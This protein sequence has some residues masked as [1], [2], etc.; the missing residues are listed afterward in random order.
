MPTTSISGAKLFYRDEGE[1]A[2]LLFIHAFPL[3]ST[4]WEAQIQAFAPHMRVIAPDLP[5]FGP[6]ILG[7]GDKSIDR[8]ADT[9][10]ALLD[11]LGIERANVIGLSMGGYTALALVRRHPQRVSALV[12]ADT[13]APADTEDARAKRTENAQIVQTHGQDALSDRMLAT[14]LSPDAPDSLSESVR[15]MVRANS[16][17]GLTAALKALANRADATPLLGQ[18]HV[19]TAIIVGEHDTV[20]PLS[21][22]QALHQGIANSTLT[23]IPNAAHLSN[24]EAPEAFNAALRAAIG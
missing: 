22:A 2:P 23:V 20:T 12:L 13:K 1:G 3:N 17:E 6:S 21:D 19:P 24:L 10:A 9:I 4:M 18:I 7:S 15:S 11:D 8:Y 5:G 14:L 16:R